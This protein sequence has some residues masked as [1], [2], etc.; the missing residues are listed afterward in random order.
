MNLKMKHKNENNMLDEVTSDKKDKRSI[1]HVVK[2]QNVT[3][4]YYMYESDMQRALGMMGLKVPRTDF[5]ALDDLTIGFEKGEVTAILGRN[6]SG[7]STLLKLI[8]GVSYP[9]SGSITVDGRISALLELRSNFNKEMTGREN[10][11]YKALTM[12]ISRAEIEEVMDD[13]IEFADLGVHINEP[14]RTYSSGMKARLGFAVAVNI[15]P[16]ILIVDE[17]LSVGDSVFRMKCINKMNEFREQGKTILFVSHSMNTVKAFCTRAIWINKGK[18][19][20]EGDMEDVVVQ[21]SE[22]LKEQRALLKQKKKEDREG[23]EDSDLPLTKRDIVKAGKFRLINLEGATIESVKF[24][25]DWGFTFRYKVMR[26]VSM[27]NLTFT[28][29]N[30]EDVEVYSSDKAAV[31]LDTSLGKYEVKVMLDGGE[32]M[33]G[34]Y[35]ITVDI[36]DSLSAM[37]IGVARLAAI[38]IKPTRYKGTGIAYLPYRTSQSKLTEGDS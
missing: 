32:L 5:V 31:E 36:W 15:N 37:K 27:L 3:K 20:A 22:F 38:D 26:D 12:G 14:F 1:E 13:I 7:K 29:F 18:L 16:D 21:Y 6:G 25:D 23:R 34:A 35:Y 24:D 8:S 2:I 33:P 10:I 9:D 11:Y 28:I 17:A 4:K 19:M 30:S